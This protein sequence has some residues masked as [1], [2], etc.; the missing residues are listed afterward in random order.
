VGQRLGPLFE[1]LKEV[2][3]LQSVRIPGLRVFG[4]VH[5]PAV[6]RPADGKRNDRLVVRRVKAFGAGDFQLGGKGRPVGVGPGGLD[7]ADGAACE[8]K[9]HQGVPVSP[10]GVDPDHVA[11]GPADPVDVVNRKVDDGPAAP[12]FVGEPV[13]AP[14]FGKSPGAGGPDHLGLADGAAFH[15]PARGLIVREKAY[16]VADHQ[17]DVG[18][19]A[20]LD[21]RLSVFDRQGD[22]LFAKDVLACGSGFL[23]KG[24]V[25]VCG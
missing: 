21:H 24:A 13:V 8:A 5:V 14:P 7:V 11:K 20:R 10:L 18:L 22:G 12:R 16:D 19:F 15:Q 23:G 25:E 9:G 3:E 2:F 6:D 4:L 17:R 1:A